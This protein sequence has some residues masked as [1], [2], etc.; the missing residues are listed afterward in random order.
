MTSATSS[1][2]ANYEYTTLGSPGAYLSLDPSQPSSPDNPNYGAVNC[3]ASQ[4][5]TTKVI[6]IGNLDG[7]VSIAHTSSPSILLRLAV[8]GSPGFQPS[9]SGKTYLQL[10]YGP[11]ATFKRD[12]D[13]NNK[14][15]YESVDC[16]GYFLRLQPPGSDGT[17]GVVNGQWVDPCINIAVAGKSLP[18][19]NANA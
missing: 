4:D 7:T 1:A 19:R 17:P 5:A 14:T 16:P 8:T 9:G 13:Y 12:T 11:F 10:G 6:V 2:N 18:P 3:V 15:A